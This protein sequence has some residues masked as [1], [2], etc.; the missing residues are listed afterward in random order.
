MGELHKLER[1]FSLRLQKGKGKPTQVQATANALNTEGQIKISEEAD[2][3]LLTSSDVQ[4]IKK[5]QEQE[6]LSRKT[7]LRTLFVTMLTHSNC[8]ENA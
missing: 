4:A 5:V 8:Q 1:I 6:D 7:L 2:C 3:T